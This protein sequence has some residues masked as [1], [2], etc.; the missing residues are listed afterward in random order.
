MIMYLLIIATILI[1]ISE[2]NE[3]KEMLKIINKQLDYIN[4]TLWAESEIKK[5]EKKED[6]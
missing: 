4:I 5:E 3:I 6:F 1:I 2:L